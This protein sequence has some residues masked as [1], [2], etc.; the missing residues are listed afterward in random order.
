MST[1]AGTLLL[2]QDAGFE[3]AVFARVFNAR[4]PT[5]RM[6][7]AVLV[8][9]NEQDVVAGVRYAADKG[10]SVAVRSGGHS[11]AVWS[12]QNDTLLIDLGK[13]TAPEYD[14]S[15]GIVSAGPAIEGGNELDAFLAERG[16]FFA[17]GHCPS[18]GIGG[19]LLQGG[20]G[21]CER[22]WGWAAESIVAIDVVTADGELVRADASQN[23][24]LYWAARG[25][26]PS[27]PG[28]VT[29]FHLATRPRVKSV[30][31]SV[32]VYDIADFAEVMAWMYEVEPTISP[33]VEIVC[34]SLCPPSENG[35]PR[36]RVYVVTGLAL[37]ESEEAAREALSPLQTC[38]IIDRAFENEVYESSL[39]QQRESQIQ[40]NPE[41]WRYVAD[42]VWVDGPTEEIIDA[43]TPVFT[44]S[45][46][47]DAFTIWFGNGLMRELPDMA[48]SLQAPAYIA[49]YLAYEDSANDARN[50][51]WLNDAMVAA[52]P[53][54]VGQYLGDSDMTNRQLRFMADANFAKL[55]DIIAKRD[56]EGRFVRYLAK[57]SSTVNRNHWEV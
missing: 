9:E 57:D 40:M 52:Q 39:A 41:N 43:L 17:G 45:P 2:P 21:W 19:F 49:T 13:L 27:F 38:P 47:P 14:E 18:V 37:S 46:E 56:P 16:R 50:R 35:E 34:V 55:H 54:T 5:D 3:Q 53:V 29:R 8:A 25:A 6:P 24:D 31:H 28:I 26:G 7:S 11:W 4:R 36:K 33:D 10:L 23:S 1:V 48:F 44:T 20:Q 51:A 32:Q 22:G 12:V 30:V 42:N 15:T